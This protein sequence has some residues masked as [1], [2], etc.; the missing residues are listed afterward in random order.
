MKN[1]QHKKRG[2]MDS[3]AVVDPSYHRNLIMDQGYWYQPHISR[4]GAEALLKTCNC[5]AFLV[6]KSSWTGF[7]AISSFS[8]ADGKITHSLV[9]RNSIGQYTIQGQENVSFSKL[10][11]MAL[12]SPK[13]SSYDPLNEDSFLQAKRKKKRSVSFSVIVSFRE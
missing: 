11:D 10:R 3:R 7:F 1:K 5:N 2:Q 8:A 9:R 13:L 6:R 12:G 4:D